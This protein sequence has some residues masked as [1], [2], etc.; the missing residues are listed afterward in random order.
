M[1]Y[2]IK[3]P[4]DLIIGNFYNISEPVYDDYNENIQKEIDLVQVISKTQNSVILK[5]IQH[6]FTYERTYNHLLDCIIKTL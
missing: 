2:L 4:K 6:D 3:N 5:N 1:I